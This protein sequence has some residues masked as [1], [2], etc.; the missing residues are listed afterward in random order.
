ML[1]ILAKRDMLG[2][3]EFGM[4]FKGTCSPENY[5]LKD[6]ISGT[7]IRYLEVRN[8]CVE[9]VCIFGNISILCGEHNI[10]RAKRRSETF[11]IL[12]NITVESR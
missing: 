2:R 3:Q 8:T 10:E 5:S 4:M 11:T 1:F 9:Y 7:I 12:I 6:E